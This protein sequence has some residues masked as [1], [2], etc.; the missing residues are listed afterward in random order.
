[1]LNT[2]YTFLIFQTRKKWAANIRIDFF[3]A[4]IEFKFNDYS[5]S[6]FS[7]NDFKRK[8]K[9]P[10]NFRGLKLVLFRIGFFQILYSISHFL[11]G[12]FYVLKTFANSGSCCSIAFLGKFN[13]IFFNCSYQ[14]F[15]F[16]VLFHCFL[17]LGL[18]EVYVGLLIVFKLKCGNFIRH[19]FTCF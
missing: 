12:S 15:D 10:N 9:T 19:V 13:Y 17:F 16:F 5:Q 11:T 6:N 4:N 14:L 7:A 8:R 18:T 1:M 3:I 2:D